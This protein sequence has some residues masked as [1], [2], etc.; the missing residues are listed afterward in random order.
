MACLDDPK[1][2][3]FAQLLAQGKSQSAA[4]RTVNP[5]AKKWKDETVWSKASTWAADEKVRARVAEL[6]EASVSEAVC[7]RREIL[8]KLSEVVRGRSALTEPI[9]AVRE[10]NKMQGFYAPDQIQHTVSIFNDAD[11]EEAL[12]EA[13]KASEGGM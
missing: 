13:R 1:L 4:L 12:E 11:A 7:T 9:D 8:E 2:E 5:K 6:Q 10:L 3:R